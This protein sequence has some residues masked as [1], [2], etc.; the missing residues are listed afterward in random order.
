MTKRVEGLAW[1]ICAL[2]VWMG[3]VTPCAAQSGTPIPRANP[4]ASPAHAAAY[5]PETIAALAPSVWMAHSVERTTAAPGAPNILMI[6]T[7]DQDVQSGTLA[8]MPHLQELLVNQGTSFSNMLVP[9]SLCCPSRTTIL[10]GQFPHNTGVLTNSLPNGGFEK[11]FS[12]NLEASTLATVLHGAGYRTVLLGKYLNGYPNTATPMYIP[13]GWDE[14]YSPIAGDPYGEFKYT[15]NEN[16]TAVMYGSTPADYLTDVIYGKAT[17]F[18]RRATAA[19]PAQPFFIYFATYAPHAPYT[20][21]PR[22]ANLF[23]NVTAPH[24]PSFNEADVSGKPAY[25]SSKP[26]LTAMEINGIDADFRN[27]LRALQAVDEAIAGL[28]TTLTSTGRLANTYIFFTADNGYHMGEHRLLPGK[29]TPYE[30]DIH[31]PLVVRGPG[32]PIGAV[33]D[34]YAGNLDLAETYADLAGVQPMVFSDGRS[35]KGLLQNPPTTVWRQGFLLEEF[36]TGEFD[37]PDARV[38]LT[39]PPD[40]QDLAT[41]VPI[42]SYFGFQAP[43][44]KYV[45]YETGEKE[46]Y[47]A[48]DPYELT[49]VAS[50]VNPSISTA[51]TSYVSLFENCKGDGCRAADAV[52]PPALLTADFGVSPPSPTTAAPVTLTATASGTAPYTFTW[53]IDT[54]GVPGATVTANLTAGSHTVTLHV[55]DAIGADASVTKTVTVAASTLPRRRA[56]KH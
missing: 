10:R 46:L 29:Y 7:D 41:V 30:T 16:G 40:K 42:P 27:R 11:A 13:P 19:N 9:L 5:P 34:Q 18:I 51:L 48:S 43:G 35:L 31:V 52:V 49:N 12:L 33:R 23:P 14:W 32:V 24:Y 45:E 4:A 39:E 22:H 54:G 50:K 17:D 26:L 36:G 55:H 1:T 53:N 47:T 44:Y 37:P 56:V 8:Y 21:A 15:L 6:L 2:L 28:V 38:G 3:L 25:I 20:P